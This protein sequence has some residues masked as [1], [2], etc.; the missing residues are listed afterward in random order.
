MRIFQADEPVMTPGGKAKVIYH[1]MS[2]SEP[3]KVAYYAVQL[4]DVIYYPGISANT[5]Y[6]A[7]EVKEINNG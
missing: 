1:K 7:R 2:S 5:L 4:D 6:P 3:D